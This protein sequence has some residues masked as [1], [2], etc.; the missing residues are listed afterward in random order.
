MHSLRFVV[1]LLLSG[2]GL[3]AAALVLSTPSA[4]AAIGEPPPGAYRYT[5]HPARASTGRILQVYVDRDFDE[6]ER[7]RIASAI[8]QWNHVL[9]GTLRLQAQLLFGSATARD[10]V[11]IR[12]SGGWFIARIDSRHPVARQAEARQAMGLTVGGSGGGIVYVI[13]DRFPS[14]ELTA[15]MLHEFGHVLG[16]GHDDRGR[17]MA[18]VYDRRNGHCIDR[19]AAAMVAAAQRVPV[20]RFNWCVGPGL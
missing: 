7:Q 16:A 17:L 4:N 2:L 1:A 14:T 15:V 13:S 8:K 6:G 20:A 10:L 3:L 5:D 19:G 9:N 18:S 11:Q 12:R